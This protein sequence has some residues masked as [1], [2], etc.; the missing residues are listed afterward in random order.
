[1][2]WF[3][4]F[5]ESDST[6]SLARRS[7]HRPKLFCLYVVFGCESVY[8]DQ[9]STCNS[10]VCVVFKWHGFS[11][12]SEFFCCCCVDS[13]YTNVSIL[14]NPSLLLYYLFV[15]WSSNGFSLLTVR[16]DHQF[17][18]RRWW[19]RQNCQKWRYC[20][21][22]LLLLLYVAHCQVRIV[23]NRNVKPLKPNWWW[24]FLLLSCTKLLSWFLDRHWQ[25]EFQ[26]CCCF[27][28]TRLLQ[29]FGCL[30]LSYG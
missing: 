10:L 26:R 14:P 9:K 15:T 27:F 30:V 1:L 22:L 29:M 20:L 17:S 23:K 11:D 16:S 7:S 13:P 21:L 5:V 4:I 19:A 2:L 8:F 6:I 3:D 18:L 12:Q 25:R 28:C 24:Q